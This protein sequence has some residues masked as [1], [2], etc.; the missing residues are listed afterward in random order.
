[1]ELCG[2]RF[3]SDNDMSDARTYVKALHPFQVHVV[4]NVN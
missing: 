1:M 4:M 3:E 2:S